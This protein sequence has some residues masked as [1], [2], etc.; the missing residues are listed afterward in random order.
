MSDSNHTGSDP[1]PGLRSD[2]DGEVTVVDVFVEAAASPVAGGRWE[3]LADETVRYIR[4]NGEVVK[5]AVV[6]ASTL[7]DSPTWR[8]A[9]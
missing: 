7:R 1:E 9:T 6:T 8:R 3:I 4:P 5:P 2:P